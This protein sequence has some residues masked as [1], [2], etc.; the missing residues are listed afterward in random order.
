MTSHEAW[1]IHKCVGFGVYLGPYVD[2][3]VKHDDTENQITTTARN[4]DAQRGNLHCPQLTRPGEK[5]SWSPHLW[6]DTVVDDGFYTFIE[7]GSI[8]LHLDFEREK[9]IVTLFTAQYQNEINT[10]MEIYGKENVKIV[11]GLIVTVDR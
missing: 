5:E 2:C 11:Y 7:N 1:L 6:C 8:F 9:Q 3:F 4:Y 10:L